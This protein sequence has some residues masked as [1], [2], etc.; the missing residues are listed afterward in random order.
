MMIRLIV[1]EFGRFMQGRAASRGL[2]GFRTLLHRA[3]CSR[4]RFH[5]IVMWFFD[6]AAL[7][8]ARKA[9]KGQT[10]L[11]PA[12]FGTGADRRK[13]FQ[14][15][16]RVYPALRD[17]EGHAVDRQHVGGDAVVYVMSLGVAHHVVEAVAQD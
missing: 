5:T 14:A 2:C 10:C 11:S 8:G 1:M 16:L 7:A 3:A 6:R 17:G 9:A 4:A 15:D 12:I 13:F